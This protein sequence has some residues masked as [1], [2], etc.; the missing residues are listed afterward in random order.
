MTSGCRKGLSQKDCYDI[1]ISDSNSDLEVSEFENEVG[2]HNTDDEKTYSAVSE[3]SNGS[4]SDSDTLSNDPAQQFLK[5]K[6]TETVCVN[7]NDWLNTGSFIFATVPDQ[8]IVY[9]SQFYENMTTE[10]LSPCS[11]YH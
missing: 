6:K 3:N 4:D 7:S 9:A 2:F 1:L 8:S 5:G 10:K 11:R